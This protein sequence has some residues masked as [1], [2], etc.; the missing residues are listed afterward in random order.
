MELDK[1][2]HSIILGEEKPDFVIHVPGEMEQNL[3]VIEV[4]P[5]TV[6][7]HIKELKKDFDKLKMFITSEI[8]YYRAIMLI[9]GSVNGDL[10][11]NIR[12]EIEKVHDEKTITLWH[13]SLNKKP[14]IIGG[15]KYI[16]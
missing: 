12:Q 10:P 5:V 9:Y 13:D 11:Q 2:S 1:K 14:K 7:D 8:S 3:V 16:D 4:K 6:K 15:G